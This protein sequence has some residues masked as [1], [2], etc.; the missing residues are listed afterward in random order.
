MNHF[1]NRDYANAIN[2]FNQVPD[3]MLGRLYAGFSYMHLEEYDDAE[4][5]FKEIIDEG[6]NMF[7]DQAAWHLGLCY[8]ATDKTEQAKT[9]LT[10]IANSNTFYKTKALELLTRMGN[11]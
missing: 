6:N 2:S 1:A 7:I 9:T 4:K 8:L 10:D 11:D 3:N 5:K